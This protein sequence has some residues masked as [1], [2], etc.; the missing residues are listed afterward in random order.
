MNIKMQPDPPHSNFFFLGFLRIWKS[1][2]MRIQSYE[3][4]AT[5]FKTM[6]P[7]TLNPTSFIALMRHSSR[8]HCRSCCEYRRIL[9]GI[10]G[11]TPRSTERVLLSGPATLLSKRPWS[12]LKAAVN[13]EAF[14]WSPSS[15]SLCSE[16]PGCRC[17]WML[18][19]LFFSTSINRQACQLVQNV[20]FLLKTFP[21][22]SRHRQY[23]RKQRTKQLSTLQLCGRCTPWA[24]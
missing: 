21:I 5:S 13:V 16:S 4:L 12:K 9:D 14:P 7:V 3:T 20:A 6:L 2:T 8:G 23:V 18:V 24:R 22:F 19:Y 1:V 15:S 10:F 17:C 11:G